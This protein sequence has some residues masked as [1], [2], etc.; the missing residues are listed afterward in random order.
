MD[1][2]AITLEAIHRLSADRLSAGKG[3]EPG[4]HQVRLLIT[5]EID[6]ETHHESC[7][8]ELFIPPTRQSPT[9]FDVQ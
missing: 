3:A 8:G 7:S 4:K 2:A 9:R 5:A 1:V 6:G